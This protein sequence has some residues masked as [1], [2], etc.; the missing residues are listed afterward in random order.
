MPNADCG[1]AIPEGH[2]LS[3]GDPLNPAAPATRP[4]VG[5]LPDSA[6]PQSAIR[7][8]QSRI[9]RI[10][11]YRTLWIIALAVFAI[12]QATKFWIVAHVPFD[13]MHSHGPG[14]DIEI[15]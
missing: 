2:R 13:P 11:S 3:S 4:A 15:I 6:N 1:S 9:A 8:P 5:G 7:P 12:D 14:S 10:R